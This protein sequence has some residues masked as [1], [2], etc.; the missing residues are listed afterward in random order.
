M[1]IGHNVAK[2]TLKI[3]EKV[4][5][6]KEKQK[7]SDKEEICLKKAHELYIEQQKRESPVINRNMNVNLDVHSD[8]VDLSAYRNYPDEGGEENPEQVINAEFTQQKG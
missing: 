4:L 2:L 7:L 3:A 1:K 8:L 6:D 5:K